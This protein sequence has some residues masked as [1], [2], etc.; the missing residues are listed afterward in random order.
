MPQGQ[1][2]AQWVNSGVGRVWLPMAGCLFSWLET[3]FQSQWATQG[4]HTPR[5]SQ[6]L[7]PPCVTPI[8]KCNRGNLYPGILWVWDLVNP[9]ALN[10]NSFMRISFPVP[11]KQ[12]CQRHL[13]RGVWVCAWMHYL[14]WVGAKSGEGCAGHEDHR[15]STPK[16]SNRRMSTSFRD[17]EPVPW[18]WLREGTF[19]RALS[20]WIKR[21]TVLRD[22]GE[23]APA[24][25][26]SH[27]QHL[28]FL[29]NLSYFSPIKC[30]C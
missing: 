15:V 30:S 13:W 29:G 18:Q 9:L 2:E 17:L 26:C 25:N 28:I 5:A 6:A 22:S 7:K 24:V 12:L 27:C 1:A 21:Q 23:A 14:E 11:G 20:L 10:H 8:L 3:S 16:C 19:Q 4:V